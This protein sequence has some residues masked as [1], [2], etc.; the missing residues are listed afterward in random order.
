MNIPEKEGGLGRSHPVVSFGF[1]IC[2][3]GLTLLCVHPVY[4]VISLVCAVFYAVTL[5]GRKAVPV[6]ITGFLFFLL[7]TLISP[8]LNHHGS[9]Y[10]FYIGYNPVTL[11]V[12]VYSCVNATMI[13]SC[14]MWFFCYSIIITSDK[15][16]YIF[17][18]AF[19]SLGLMLSIVLRLIPKLSQQIKVIAESQCTFGFSYNQGNILSRIKSC[20]RI[21]SV[22]V[23][24]ALEDAV[25]TA[26]SMK[27][28]GY[29]RGKRSFFSLF[30]FKSRDVL[31]LA[32][33][34]FMVAACVLAW[35]TGAA[36]VMYYPV[37]KM[38]SG[39]LY[40]MLFYMAFA[41]L[42]LLPSFLSIKEELRWKF[43]ARKI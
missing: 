20:T 32:F 2:I 8:L 28:R 16:L 24:W 13:F 43:C 25:I 18:R 7:T 30:R 9:T 10:L 31:L 11:E 4:A 40:S 33:I 17:G 35:Y 36:K 14:I 39:N 41:A 3:T 22:L 27:A 15:F 5:A 23:T 12:F 38:T 21:L 19:P 1:F 37:I 34:V 26:D 29:G 42:G 6:I